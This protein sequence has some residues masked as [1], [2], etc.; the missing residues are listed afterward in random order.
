MSAARSASAAILVAAGLAG[1]TTTQDVN[2]RFALKAQRILAGREPLRVGDANPDVAVKRVELVRGK[3][4]AIVVELENTS[5]APLADVP[6]AVGVGHRSLNV[7]GHLDYFQTRVAAL[8]PHR[9]ARWVFVTSKPVPRGRPFA[10]V[11]T[12]DKPSPG[13]VSALPHLEVSG[14]ATRARLR[15]A[16]DIPQYNLPVYALAT[17]GGRY[18][19]AGRATVEELDKHASSTLAIRLAGR[20]GTSP[21]ELEALPTIFR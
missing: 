1:C 3:R 6:I 13:A 17:R 14:T 12:Q 16:S 2:Q 7:R 11:G 9:T 21:V 5:S 20:A 10:R 15:N 19:A 4:S 18:V 8:A